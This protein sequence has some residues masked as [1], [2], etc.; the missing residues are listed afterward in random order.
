MSLPNAI[1]LGTAMICAT[2]LAVVVIA[3]VWAAVHHG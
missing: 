1:V 3:V 2:Q